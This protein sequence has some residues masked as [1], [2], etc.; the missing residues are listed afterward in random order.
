MHY[1][2]LWSNMLSVLVGM[3]KEFLEVMGIF[4]LGKTNKAALVEAFGTDV[5]MR[6]ILLFGKGKV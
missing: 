4:A 3:V 5:D 1:G 6:L 2:A